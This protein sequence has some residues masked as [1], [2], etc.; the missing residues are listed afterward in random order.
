MNLINGEKYLYVNMSTVVDDLTAYVKSLETEETTKHCKCEWIVHPDDIRK[1]EGQARRIRKG[2]ATL[3]CP[4]H[5]KEGF[6]LGFLN[7]MLN[8]AGKPAIDLSTYAED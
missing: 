8:Q 2:E 7:H 3:D 5:T 4:V 6:L 1:P